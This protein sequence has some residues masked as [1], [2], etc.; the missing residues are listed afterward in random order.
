[1]NDEKQLKVLV[2]YLAMETYYLPLEAQLYK[3]TETGDWKEKDSIAAYI[4]DH[5]CTPDKK[6]SDDWQI[7]DWEEVEA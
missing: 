5:N 3:P 6:D 1:M 4:C 2:C 7:V